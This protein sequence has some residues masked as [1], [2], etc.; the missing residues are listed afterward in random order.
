M[1][2][3]VLLSVL[4]FFS[5]STFAQTYQLGHKTITYQDSARNNRNIP[6]ELFYPAA[7]A[8]NDVAILNDQFPIIVFGHGFVM[9]NPDLYDYIWNALIPD[10]Y[11]IAFP[12]T[13]SSPI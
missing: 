8:G 2:T 1:R 7:T 13:E 11:I 5:F 3:F 4:L 9:A 12:T 10:G 6:T